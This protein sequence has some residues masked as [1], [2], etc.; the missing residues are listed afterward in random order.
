[1]TKTTRDRQR[2]N[3]ATWGDRNSRANADMAPESESKKSSNNQRA[4]TS[5]NGIIAPFHKGAKGTYVAEAWDAKLSR[6]RHA[7]DKV[8]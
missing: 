8:S 6:A 1:M 3:R 4:K 7:R 2:G 5:I